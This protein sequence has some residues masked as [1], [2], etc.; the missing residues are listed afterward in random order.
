MTSRS[1]D[2]AC[3]SVERTSTPCWAMQGEHGR[4]LPSARDPASLG[5]PACQASRHPNGPV[6]TKFL[7]SEPRLTTRVVPSDYERRIDERHAIH[8]IR[9][10]RVGTMLR[11]RVASCCGDRSVSVAATD[12]SDRPCSTVTRCARSAVNATAEAMTA[13][14]ST[15]A[16][17]TTTSC[18]ANAGKKRGTDSG[19]IAARRL[20]PQ[21]VLCGAGTLSEREVTE[22][23]LVDA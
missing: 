12:D 10:M 22:L 20:V 7:Q 19:P 8:W 5:R 2:C 1:T 21:Q 6:S 16:S 9:S 11:T 3:I 18:A 17:W 23:H 14:K 4:R 13:R 15:A